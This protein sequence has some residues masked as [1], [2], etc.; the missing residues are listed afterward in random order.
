LTIRFIE[1]MPLDSARAW[2]RE[3][4]VPAKEVLARLQARF[5]LRPLLTDTPAV[6]AQRWAFA[7][8]G[9]E[10]GIIAPVT[11]PFCS[12]CSRIRITADGKIR[13]CLFSL[14]EHD[15]RTQLRCGAPDEALADWLRSVV[16]EKQARHHIGQP[17]FVPPPRSMSCI[18]G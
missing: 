14:T 13:T 17:D 8:G 3:M 10:I 2:H 9:G 5:V 1:F 12:Q 18:G 16:W 15:L 7:E 11:Q 6:T 4:V